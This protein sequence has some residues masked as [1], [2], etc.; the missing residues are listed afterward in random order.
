ML[1]PPARARSLHRALPRAHHAC[2]TLPAIRASFDRERDQFTNLRA[3]SVLWKRRDVDEDVALSPGGQNE[4]KAAVVVPAGDRAV[5]AHVQSMLSLPVPLLTSVSFH[6]AVRT[7]SAQ[8]SGFLHAARLTRTR[9]GSDRDIIRNRA[10]GYALDPNGV[11]LNDSPIS[12]NLPGA[13]GALSASAGDMVRWQ[14]ALTRRWASRRGGAAGS[15]RRSTKGARAGIGG[16]RLQ[17]AGTTLPQR[18]RFA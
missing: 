1:S 14:I 2:G 15:L 7:L 3:H 16:R 17:P 12:M 11:R 6:D 18:Q 10:Q 8:R 9:Y 5:G 4:A 13:A